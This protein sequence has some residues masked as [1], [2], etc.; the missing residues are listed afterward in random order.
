MHDKRLMDYLPRGGEL[1]CNVGYGCV[2]RTFK[3][4]H[5]ADQNF[6]KIFNPLQTY[7]RK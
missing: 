3:P 1:L 2:A 5:F 7:G 6:G 4:L